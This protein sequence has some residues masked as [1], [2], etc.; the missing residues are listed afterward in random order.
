MAAADLFAGPLIVVRAD[1]LEA[2]CAARERDEL[3]D[4]DGV[5]RAA[6]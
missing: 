1:D 4:F 3:G 5:L 2:A 6:I